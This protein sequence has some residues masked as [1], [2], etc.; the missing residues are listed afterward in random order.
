MHETY[1]YIQ[2]KKKDFG[3]RS[4]SM[5]ADRAQNVGWLEQ[6][7]GHMRSAEVGL[8]RG[9]ANTHINLSAAQKLNQIT[10]ELIRDV[11]Q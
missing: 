11:I 5:F 1:A 6:R 8:S 4:H 3:R 2:A 10:Q 7:L 9:R